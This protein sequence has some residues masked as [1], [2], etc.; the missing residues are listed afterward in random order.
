M[1]IEI[2]LSITKRTIHLASLLCF[3]VAV[4][5]TTAQ[6]K[7]VSYDLVLA[8]TPGPDVNGQKAMTINGGLP[9][10]T[11][12][13]T[14]G[15]D[16][17]LRVRNDLGEPTSL[18]WHGLLVPNDQDGVPHVTMAPIAV[19]ETR[20]YRFRL[21]QSGTFWYHSHSGLQEQ[22]GIYGSIVITPRGGERIKTDRDVVAVLSDWTDE[23]P[24]DVLTQ[25]RAGR[26]WQSIKKG[27]AQSVLGAVQAGEFKSFFMRSLTRMPPMDLSDVAYRHFLVNG[28]P[29][30]SLEAKAGETV[31]VRLINASTATYYFI[32]FAGGPAKIIS[33]DG[34]DVQPVASGRFLMAIAETYDLLVKVPAGGAYE[35]RATA[36]DGSGQSSFFIGKGERHAAPDV[37]RANLYASMSM[38]GMAGMSGMSDAASTKPMSGMDHSSMPMNG[39]GDGPEKNLGAMKQDGMA[40]MKG[41]DHSAMK[42]PIDEGAKTKTKTLA[43]KDDGMASMK[44]MDHG[45]MGNG[46]TSAE[47][48]GSPYEMLRAVHSTRLSDTRPLHEYTFRLQGDMIRYIWTLDGKTLSEADTINVRRGERVRFTFINDTMM[49][50]PMHLHGH[51]FRVL[52]KAGDYSPL[53]HTVD[54]PPMTTRVIEF[55]ADEPGDWFMHCHVLYHMAVGM[56][57]VVHYEDAPP[58]PVFHDMKNELGS[59]H[60]PIFFFGE[61]AAL[62]QM[63]DGFVT[64][65]NNRN[66]LAASW[67]VGWGNVEKTGYEVDLTYDRYLNTFTSVFAGAELSNNEA[68]NRGIV[69]VRYLLPF[70]VQSQAWVDTQGDF[71]FSLRQSIPI[72][73]RLAM[74][75]GIEYDTLTK[76]EGVA[77]IEYVLGKRLS[78]IGQWHSEYGLGGGV[79][80]RF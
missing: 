75:G 35:L 53:K 69:G 45:S 15:D 55:A 64:L 77:G 12:R 47:R 61:G 2:N 50:H 51:F 57:R 65:Q 62:S 70:L 9:G 25:L 38:K 21:R 32:E 31:R 46:M 29:V 7:T 24:F 63:S 11:L 71:R 8:Q 6:A 36:Q 23:N 14:E 49:H 13:F 52:T 28:Q 44:G 60:D 73:S 66:G 78:L 42:M 22:L 33:A 43:K 76:W 80:I 37:P 79:A 39:E 26:E 19:G 56:A 30:S 20:E 17:V 4:V 16:A 41:M 48:P 54:V 67:E 72:T 74:Y 18:H 68:G 59:E 27:T 40:G 3:L 1:K 58:N 10:P 5:P 34:S